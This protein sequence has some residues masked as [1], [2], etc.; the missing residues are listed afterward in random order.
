MQ[1]IE[2]MIVL[3]GVKTTCI[4]QRLVL[5]VEISIIV[6]IFRSTAEGIRYEHPCKVTVLCY[7]RIV[8]VLLA[9]IP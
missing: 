5:L 9:G 8:N 7:S 3:F 6:E 2:H 4:K 1:L